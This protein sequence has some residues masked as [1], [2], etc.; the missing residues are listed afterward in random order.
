MAQP[1]PLAGHDGCHAPPVWLWTCRILLALTLSAKLAGIA[2]DA[3][4]LTQVD[5]LTGL[6]NRII[7]LLALYG[8]SALLMMS[9]FPQLIWHF[10]FALSSFGLVILAYRFWNFDNRP[11]CPCL[12]GIFHWSEWFLKYE[13]RLLTSLAAWFLISGMA[14]LFKPHQR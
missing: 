12:G 10:T 1:N 14:C 13:D 7:V 4:V 8:E 5:S 6:S 11:S 3:P 2:A 9:F